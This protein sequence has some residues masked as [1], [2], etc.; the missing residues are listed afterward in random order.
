MIKTLIVL[1]FLF[2]FF[3]CEE[4]NDIS[5]ASPETT[6]VAGDR[7]LIV[8]NI[9]TKIAAI[10]SLTEV[11]L[12][13]VRSLRWEKSTSEGSAFLEVSAY[14]NADEFPQK[15]A[16]YFSEPGYGKEGENIF[17]FENNE[18]IAVTSLYDEWIDSNT[19]EVVE[20]QHFL[21]NGE[22][23]YSR[24]KRAAFLDELADKK[25]KKI[26]AEAPSLDRTYKVLRSESPFTTTFISFIQGDESLFIL[27]GEPKDEDRYITALK[28]DS[29][30]P[31]LEKLY[32][33][34]EE[35]KY[36][37]FKITFDIIGGNG[38]PEFRVLKDIETVD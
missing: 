29:K 14:I 7:P 1:L 30:D 32:N 8:T 6:A 9:N 27:L 18:L 13:R 25:W 31:V 23:T 15:I 16:E 26:R 10:D 11:E 17:Y 36:T 12:Q 35:Y 3:S 20:Q 24:I 21:E 22:V 33:N 5:N 34:P 38:T 2:L 4:S 37:P 19:M 28:I